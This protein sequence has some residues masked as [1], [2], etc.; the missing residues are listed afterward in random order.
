MILL[1]NNI[2]FL[3]KHVGIENT[4]SED[5][6]CIVGSSRIFKYLRQ[7]NGSLNKLFINEFL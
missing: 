4:C 3:K 2:H 6:V 1:I 7:Y 5:T